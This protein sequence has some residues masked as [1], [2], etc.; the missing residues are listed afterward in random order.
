MC[1][2][3]DNG[4]PPYKSAFIPVMELYSPISRSS[5]L[6]KKNKKLIIIT[7]DT[8][9]ETSAKLISGPIFPSYL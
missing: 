4:F 9:A 5:D 8:G 1:C 6:I 3:V 7:A 2:T